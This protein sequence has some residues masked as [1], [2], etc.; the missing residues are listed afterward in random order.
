MKT[1]RA[2]LIVLTLCALNFSSVRAHKASDSYLNL[3]AA[4][5]ELTGQWDIALR[6]L[7]LAIGI[8]QNSDGLITWGEIRAQQ[9]VIIQYVFDR[10]NV[11]QGAAV[12]LEVTDVLAATHS[13]GG[14][15]VLQ[16][17]SPHPIVPD[18]LEVTYDLFFDLDAQHRGIARFTSGGAEDVRIFKPND[19]VVAFN[20]TPAEAASRTHLSGFITEGAWH[21][22]K[23]VDHVLFL[24]TLLLPSV[25]CRRAGAWEAVHS[26]RPVALD[27]TSIVTSFTVA[28]SITL[29]LAAREILQI[30]PALIES[31]IAISVILAAVN[32]VIPF[33]RG[34]TWLFAFGFGLVHG[35]GFANVFQDLGQ[36]TVGM[37]APL[38]AFNLGVELGQLAIVAAFLPVAFLLRRKSAY[39]IFALQSASVVIALIAATWTLERSLDF[40]ALPF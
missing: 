29:F 31:I 26:F 6:D 23:G 13:D 16:F 2:I 34:K 20:A 1:I 4:G 7:E 3:Q 21:I 33:L 36:S 10:L 14:Y 25:L 5:D 9:K 32:N 22:W 18:P 8:D 24:L 40:K 35:F 39:R 15:I 17:K 11:R 37:I 38:L 28:H 19:N 27:V 12:A 30:P